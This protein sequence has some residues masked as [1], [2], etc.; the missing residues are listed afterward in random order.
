MHLSTTSPHE[1]L[2]GANP[3]HLMRRQRKETVFNEAA[4]WKRG[5]FRIKRGIYEKQIQGKIPFPQGGRTA[6]LQNREGD[7]LQSVKHE[8]ATGKRGAP[9]FYF[10]DRTAGFQ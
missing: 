8:G 10:F 2:A 7:R 6:A 3:L 4:P 1:L 5:S 9:F